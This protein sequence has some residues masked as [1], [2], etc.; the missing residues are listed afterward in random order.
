MVSVLVVTLTGYAWASMQGLVS[1]LTLT[2][3]IGSDAGGPLPADGSRDIL[4][5]GLDSRTDAQGNPL[6]EEI[7]RKL[8]AGVADGELNTDTLIMLHIPNDGSKAVALSLPRDSFVDIPNGYGQHK[9]N[10]A[11]GRGKTVE[12]RRLE[13]EEGVTDPRELELKSSQEG[14]KVLISSIEQLSGRT[15]DNY[16]SINLLGFYEITKALG[17]VDVCLNDA[18]QDTYSG[19]NFAKGQQ[20]ISGAKALSF[21]RQRHGLP[22][23]DIDRVIRQQVFMA[24]LARKVLSAGTLANPSK[25]SSL[26]DAV[27]KSIVLN[28]GWD[29]LGFAKQMSGLSGGQI[30]FRTIP[31]QSLSMDTP[32]GSAVQ[33]D[34]AEVQAFIQGLS[35]TG[36]PPAGAPPTKDPA[37]AQITVQVMNTTGTTGL[38]AKVM[39]TLTS[40]GFTEGGTGNDQP[41]DATVVRH[42]PGEEAKAKRVSDALANKPPIEADPAMSPGKVTVLLGADYPTEI[43]AAGGGAQPGR[44]VIPA[45]RQQPPSTPPLNSDKPIT[46]NGVT[47]VN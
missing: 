41:R 15:I 9:I 2:D 6:P 8:R 28:Q 39:G 44:S 1:G 32:D 13:Q 31:I 34:P 22:R 26:M 18:V 5:V 17:G 3:V 23:G 24:G 47:C 12:R 20:T 30:E 25:L 4:L 45:D 35:K 37:N 10:S 40:L 38:A 11:Y 43:P 21:V 19:A 7:L 36:A 46:A 33:V 27:K 29:V 16:A 42:A 14:A